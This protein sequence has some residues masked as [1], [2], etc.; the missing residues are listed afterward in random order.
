MKENDITPHSPQMG[1]HAIR[2]QDNLCH[3]PGACATIRCESS[4]VHVKCYI[5]RQRSYAAE[6]Y[7]WHK[8]RWKQMSA[9][10]KN[11]F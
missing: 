3:L 7:T 5:H 1:K 2:D 9:W 4:A 10:T 8:K 11:T 6:I